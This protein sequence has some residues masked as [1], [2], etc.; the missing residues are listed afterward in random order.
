MSAAPSPHTLPTIDNTNEETILKK[1]KA[2]FSDQIIPVSKYTLK[3]L[4]EELKTMAVS[5]ASFLVKNLATLLRE[6][7]ELLAGI[8]EE[9]DYVKNDLES[10]R[11]FLRVADAVEGDDEEIKV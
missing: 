6:K 4:L 9:V 2:V 3:N 8:R 5:A 7:V 1:K 11:A 10:M